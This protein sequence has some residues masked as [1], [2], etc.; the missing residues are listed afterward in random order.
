[1]QTIAR[2]G[3]TAAQVIQIVTDPVI[4]VDAGLELLDTSNAFVSDLS[5]WLIPGGSSIELGSYRTI[6]R[7]CSLKLSYEL[8]WGRDRVRP[9]MT[10]TSA[11]GTFRADLGVFILSTPSTVAGEDIQTWEVQGYDLLEVLDHPHGRSHH[12]ATGTEYLAAVSGLVSAAGLTFTATA[13]GDA[14]ALPTDRLWPIDSD[15]TTLNIVNDLLGSA[16]YGAIYADASGTLRA[17]PYQSPAD[18]AVEWT[19]DAQDART[20]VG[21]MRE[22][23]AE[24]TDAPN[25]WVGIIDDPEWGAVSEGDG[26]YTVTNQSDGVTSIDARGRTIT[27]VERLGAAN[28]ASLVSQVNR[29]ADSDKRVAL[30]MP[31]LSVGPNPLHGHFDVVQVT[32]TELGFDRKCVVRSW[33]LSL[34]GDDMRLEVRAV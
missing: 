29:M 23:R 11:S 3:L 27:R 30:E 33:A 19:Y 17:R 7:T 15:T 20:T 5:E 26:I 18:R 34:A 32:D 13:A 4:E 12:V 22:L 16:G 28:Q 10:V 6:H 21:P 9:Y 8:D 1:M 14:P 24:Y 2:D 31:N 25:K